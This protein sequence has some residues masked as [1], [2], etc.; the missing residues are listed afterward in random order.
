MNR[1]QTNYFKVSHDIISHP[2][3][4]KLSTQAKSLYLYLCKLENKYISTKS[5]K[6]YFI[7]SD[8]QLMKDTGMSQRAITKAKQEL[9]NNF[10]VIATGKSRRTKYEI[11]QPESWQLYHDYAFNMS[12]TMHSQ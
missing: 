10:V 3:F 2:E 8:R 11:M 6:N 12:A 1:V 9:S 7:R 4:I 5:K